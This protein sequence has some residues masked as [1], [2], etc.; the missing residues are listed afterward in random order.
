MSYY[1]LTEEEK[2]KSSLQRTRTAWATSIGHKR[3][4]NDEL[5]NRL[6]THN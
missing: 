5:N 2:T 6:V 1:I 4:T 3:V